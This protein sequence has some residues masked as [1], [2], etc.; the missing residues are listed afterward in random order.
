MFCNNHKWS[1][2]FKNCVSVYCISAYDIIHQL[3][4][5]NMCVYVCVCV[6]M[7]FKRVENKDKIFSQNIKRERER[8]PV[9]AQWE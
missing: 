4:F 3:Y 7:I 2:T 6:C 1:I 8:L 5:K 9:V